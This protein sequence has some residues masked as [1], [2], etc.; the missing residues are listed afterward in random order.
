LRG[1]TI[2]YTAS[3]KTIKLCP[4]PSSKEA[5]PSSGKEASFNA[6]VHEAK[7]GAK[8]GKKRCKQ[9][10]QQV[11]VTA[12][13]DG[14]NDEEAGGS[15]M[16][17]I[18]TTTLSSKRQAWPPIDH[19]KQLLEE[20]CLNHA[21]PIKHKLK[22]CGMIKNFMILGSHTRSMELDEEL[23]GSDTMPFPGRTRS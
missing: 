2:Q 16:G 20:A 13:Y 17:H 5:T 1:V 4:A 8:G 3:D 19:F 12:D 10:P 11:M 22:D 7:V 14:G 15:G 6:T 23:G 9:H 21:Y 18:A